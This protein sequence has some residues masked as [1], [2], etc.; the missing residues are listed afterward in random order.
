VSRNF[1]R[2]Y[3]RFKAHVYSLCV[4]VA[5]RLSATPLFLEFVHRN[6]Y[7]AAGI[8]VGDGENL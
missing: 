5:A 8:A 3:K 2:G 1:V 6:P 7:F 4:A